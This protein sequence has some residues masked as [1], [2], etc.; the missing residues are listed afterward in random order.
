MSTAAARR[1]SM[2][3]EEF[4][5]LPSVSLDVPEGW[6][7]F[8]WAGAVMGVKHRVSTGGFAPNVL[9]TIERWPGEISDDDAEQV[10]RQRIQAARGKELDS[11]RDAEGLSLGAEQ[12]HPQH[13]TMLVRYRQQIV[14]HRGMTDAITVIGTFTKLQQDGVGEEIRG[15]VDSIRVSA[16]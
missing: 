7:S 4:P 12:R 15:I 9:V 1:L 2:P 16:S 5:S 6:E 14:R 13:G 8:V 11:S 3:G 10:L